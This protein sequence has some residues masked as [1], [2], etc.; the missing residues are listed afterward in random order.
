M[1]KKVRNSERIDEMYAL[2]WSKSSRESPKFVENA[3]NMSEG[4][5][6]KQ[7]LVEE[8][9][10]AIRVADANLSAPCNSVVTSVDFSHENVS[11]LLTAG[12]D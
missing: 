4:K 7:K 8:E 1:R 6:I 3:T 5:D 9:F 10:N 2:N 11:L 12:F